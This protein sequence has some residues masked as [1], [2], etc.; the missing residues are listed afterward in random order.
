MTLHGKRWLIVLG[1]ILL[2][3]ALPVVA[4]YV[5][6]GSYGLNAVLGHGGSHW[7]TVRPDDPRLSSSMRL[8][9]GDTVP[10]AKPGSFSWRP[11]DRGFE[12]AELPVLADGAEVDRVLL[13]RIDPAYFRFEVRNAPAG[14]E[15]TDWIG[16]IKAALVVNGSYF[17]RNGTPETPLVSAGIRLGPSSYDAR[18][19]A[20]VA[21][22]SLVAIRDLQGGDWRTALNGADDAMVSYPLLVAPDGSDRVKADRRWLANR[23]FVGQDGSGRII[24]GTT[25]DAFFSLDRLAAFL[26]RAP[27]GLTIALNLDGGPV[28]CQEIRLKDYTRSWCGEWEVTTRGADLKLLRRLVGDRR[29]ALPIVLAALPK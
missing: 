16:E 9:L 14:K 3:L 29:W 21:S 26:R 24:I 18:H 10:E 23:S 13:A 19:G 5:R 4:L 12:V 2:G 1:T 7:V 25:A 22:P 15:A 28:A 8:A 20:F 27:L 17:L 6:S 11:I